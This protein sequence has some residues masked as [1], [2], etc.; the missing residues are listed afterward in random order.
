MINAWH[1]TL[2]ATPDQVTLLLR[3]PPR[4]LLK[5]RLTPHPSHPRALLT[6]LEGLS[7]W[8]GAALDVALSVDERLQRGD[9][10][11]ALLGDTLWPAESPLVRYY[12]VCPGRPRRLAGVGDFRPMR[13]LARRETS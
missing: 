8:Q 11:S 4:D 2:R 9:G 6:L 5:A 7:L 3:D 13:Q 12:L 1:C 10:F